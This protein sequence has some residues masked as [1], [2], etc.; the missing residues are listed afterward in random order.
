M[1]VVDRFSKMGHFV[2]CNK[3]DDASN[4][5]DLYF[6]EIVRLHVI[7]NTI[8]LNQDSKL[9]SYFWNTQWMKV[10][11]KLLFSTLHPIDGWSDRGYK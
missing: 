7:P 9:L 8:V 1:V 4:V 3:T 6:K 10:G 2:A 11:T 5:A